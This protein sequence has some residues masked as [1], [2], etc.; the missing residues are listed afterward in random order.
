MH[1][2]ICGVSAFR[3][4][5]TPPQILALYPPLPDISTRVGK[6]AIARN[7]EALGG[8]GI[9]IHVLVTQRKY[10]RYSSSV[11]MHLWSQELPLGSFFEN[12]LE[13]TLSSPLFTLLTMAPHVSVTHLA[14]AMYELCGSFSVYRP[15]P[16]TQAHLDAIRNTRLSRN[17]WQQV[18]DAHGNGTSLWK[19]PPLITVHELQHYAEH[20]N[21]LRGSKQF[22][23]AAQMVTGQTASPLEAQTSMLLGASRRLAAQDLRLSR[24]TTWFG[25]AVKR[26]GSRGGSIATA[27][28]SFPAARVDK[29]L[30]SNA[31]DT[32]SM[33]QLSKAALT[34]TVPLPFKAWASTSSFSPM[35]SSSTRSA[36]MPPSIT[37]LAVRG[38][39]LNLK[40]RRLCRRSGRS[41][42]SSSSIGRRLARKRQRI[43]CV[44]SEDKQ[45]L[46][47]FS[48]A[49]GNSRRLSTVVFPSAE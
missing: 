8:L 5:R 6:L 32:S 41:V 35:S 48:D 14:M 27:T 10:L 44:N 43:R 29:H 4:L 36:D 20:I 49:K 26:V 1:E 7:P 9:P 42:R 22:R 33:I 37:S 13:I 23:Q 15:A 21:G 19:R 25:S 16:E 11:K 40:P 3:L 31:T 18:R 47:R 30:T 34:P 28:S 38:F 45:R 12:D 39:G 17:M 24:T 46:Q 2:F